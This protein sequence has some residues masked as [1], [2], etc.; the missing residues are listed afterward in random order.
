MERLRFVTCKHS[1]KIVAV[2]ATLSGPVRGI[3]TWY[4]A[5]ASGASSAIDRA[6]SGQ[7]CVE[8]YTLMMMMLT[9]GSFG[10]AI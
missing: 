2:P 4:T 8:C 10:K 3:R 7:V 9:M 1:G 6:A 5:P